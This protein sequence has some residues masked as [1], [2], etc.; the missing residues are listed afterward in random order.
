MK[1]L[2]DV[3]IQGLVFFVEVVILAIR[4]NESTERIQT[5]QEEKKRAVRSQIA[6]LAD[7]FHRSLWLSVLHQSRNE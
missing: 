7:D 3:Y 4:C 1:R 5:F 2:L 6:S